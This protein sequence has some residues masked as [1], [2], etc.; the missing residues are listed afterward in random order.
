MFIISFY[1]LSVLHSAAVSYH[2]LFFFI[3]VVVYSSFLHVL[4]YFFDLNTSFA[5]YS[6]FLFWYNS[7]QKYFEESETKEECARKA[8]TFCA[9]SYKEK[10]E[11]ILDISN[12]LEQSVDVKFLRGKLEEI[13]DERKE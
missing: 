1:E 9:D 4:T 6:N 5:L 2:T 11:A 7:H 10:I 13:I 8:W 12:A 3:I